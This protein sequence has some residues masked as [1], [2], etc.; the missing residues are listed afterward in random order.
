MSEVNVTTRD[1]G[2]AISDLVALGIGE[3]KSIFVDR[4]EGAPMTPGF[5]IVTD[6]IE[7]QFEIADV[8]KRDP[9]NPLITLGNGQKYRLH[10]YPEITHA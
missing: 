10:I 8:D 3:S 6:E 4:Q 5:K 9:N 7:N 1:L 2:H